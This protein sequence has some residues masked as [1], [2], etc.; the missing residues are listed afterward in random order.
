M[1]Y[2][3]LPNKSPESK[4][5]N[6]IKSVNADPLYHLNCWQVGRSRI[7]YDDVYYQTILLWK[8]VLIG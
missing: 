8:I 2:G 6:F 1:I 3:Q 7:V 5:R 4:T